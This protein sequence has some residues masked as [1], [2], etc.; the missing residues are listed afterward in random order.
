MWAITGPRTK[1]CAHICES[2]YIPSY[3]TACY[4]KGR[5]GDR[6][7]SLAK[8]GQIQNTCQPNALLTLKEYLMD[9][10]TP[11]TRAIG[12]KAIVEHLKDITNPKIRDLTIQELKKI[13]TGTRDL[14]F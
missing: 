4:R 11:E 8:T 7:M 6:F 2:G 14:Y 13:E 10:A 12:E 1:S 3:C 9:Y 5:T